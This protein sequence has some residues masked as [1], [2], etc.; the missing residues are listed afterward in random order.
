MGAP[1]AVSLWDPQS[2]APAPPP[3]EPCPTHLGDVEEVELHADTVVDLDALRC[4]GVDADIGGHEQLHGIRVTVAAALPCRAGHVP[5]ADVGGA[6]WEAVGD[7]IGGGVVAGCRGLH[8]RGGRRGLRGGGLLA[9]LIRLL[10]LLL[11]RI[12]ETDGRGRGGGVE[13]DTI[14]ESALRF[15]VWIRDWMV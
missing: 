8:R 9:L 15:T 13:I 5:E 11:L 4:G 6:A 2:H 7:G 1:L 3:F 14:L 12:C 10:V